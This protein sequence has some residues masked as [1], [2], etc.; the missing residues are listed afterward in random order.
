MD[1]FNN[2]VN[3]GFYLPWVCLCLNV[4]NGKLSVTKCDDKES[5]NS[6]LR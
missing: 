3:G 4:N 5:L 2:N 6:I 1:K